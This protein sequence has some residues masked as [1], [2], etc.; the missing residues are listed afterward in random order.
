MNK[1]KN[2][3]AA[4]ILMALFLTIGVGATTIKDS[5]TSI[6]STGLDMQQN[7]LQR[8]TLNNT[9]LYSPY[10]GY[11]GQIQNRPLYSKGI[12][13]VT[14]CS[15]GCDYTTIQDALNEVPYFI[16]QKY[17]VQ[18]SAGTYAEDLW[19]PPIQVGDI[20]HLT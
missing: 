1:R 11:S 17:T 16:N 7:Y 5:G 6:F 8:A 4:L 19:I 13:T 20:V 10:F 9:F 18:I 12:T 15:V 14:V 3:Y 2:I